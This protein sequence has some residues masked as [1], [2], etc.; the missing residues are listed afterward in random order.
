MQTI[1]PADQRAEDVEPEARQRSELEH[2]PRRQL[3]LERAAARG[4]LVSHRA[5]LL[6]FLP[7]VL[8]F[9]P[10]VLEYALR[11]TAHHRGCGSMR[12][13]AKDATA[14]RRGEESRNPVRRTQ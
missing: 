12:P 10:S 14:W 6:R 3:N 8:R 7:S 9:L 11:P 4:C 5:S 2:L 13:L 1:S